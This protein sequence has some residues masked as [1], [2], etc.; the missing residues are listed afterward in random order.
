MYH[1]VRQNQV[2]LSSNKKLSE[3][4]D[5]DQ[6]RSVDSRGTVDPDQSRDAQNFQKLQNVEEGTVIEKIYGKQKVYVYNQALFPQ[7]NKAQ[8]QD[9]DHQ[10]NEVKIK[11]QECQQ[12]IKVRSAELSK[13]N[14]MP[15]LQKVKKQFE[16]LSAK[17]AQLSAKISQIKSGGNS[18]DPQ[19]REAIKR[20][21]EIFTK[22]AKKRARCCGELIDMILEQGYP[23]TKHQLMQEIG[24][25]RSSS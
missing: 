2:F 21:H 14:S 8:I 15:T 6:N 9:L 25:D 13:M 12:K 7:V 17:E 23:S 5:T 24:I 10:I 20:D 4:D 1:R 18:V 19:V 16:D 11:L 22:E 3:F